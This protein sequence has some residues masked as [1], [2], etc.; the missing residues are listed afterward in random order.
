MGRNVADFSATLPIAIV[1]ARGG[2]TAFAGSSA[3][4]SRE[5]G[6][7]C[8][9]W[10][11][12]WQRYFDGLAGELV[13]DVHAP[14]GATAPH[15]APSVAWISCGAVRD[16]FAVIVAGNADRHAHDDLGRDGFVPGRASLHAV[17]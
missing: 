14:R 9:A 10:T 5:P 13:F 6:A 7:P 1:R 2:R 3:V 16:R 4:L 17:P 8:G 15:V 11:P 12:C